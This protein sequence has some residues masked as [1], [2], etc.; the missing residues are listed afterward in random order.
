V[1]RVGLAACLGAEVVAG[2]LGFA[3]TV[4]LARRL[5]PS[6]FATV[7]VALATSAWLLV[8]VRGG[9]DQVVVREAARRP[10]LIPRLTGLLLGLRLAWAAAGFVLLASIAWIGHAGST[11]MLA[12][13]L[14]LLA[15]ALVADVG[16]RARNELPLLAAIQTTR[17][18]GM[19]CFVALAVSGPVDVVAAALA[20]GVAEAIVAIS[21]AVRAARVDGW[22]RPRWGWRAA[23]VLSGRAAVA[24]LTR[25]V[26]V[27]LYA[28]DAIALMLTAG[29]C[30]PYAAGRRVV[31]VS[32]AVGLVVPT[33]LAPGLTRAR[34]KGIEEA[35]AQIGRGVGLLLGLALPAALGLM[36]TSGR[37]LPFLFGDDY[38]AG[39]VL[40][41]LVAARLPILLAAAW[42][43]S[44]LVAI[45]RERAALASTLVAGLVALVAL[46][47]AAVGL[48]PLGI[49]A[50]ALGVEAVAGVGGWV[51]LRRSGVGV[52]RGVG[53]DR[54]IVG[55]AGLAA[56][57]A[58]TASAPL[59]IT[60]LAGAIG[61]AAGWGLAG[62]CGIR[63][64]RLGVETR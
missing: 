30:G 3:A 31:F 56:S 42:F 20:P 54:L 57:V 55:C 60:C 9:L 11:V 64:A 27:G 2:A 47:A 40:L 46:P 22:P 32:V 25:F 49:G 38:R 51:A 61:Y 4:H 48:G 50:A 19:L 15:S 21:C 59:P 26:R 10:R 29:A 28:A 6:G 1:D 43:G 7:E 62:T 8:L 52:F 58:L 23:R 17:A 36:L 45:G 41:A 37:I 13:G 39:G 44:A 5:G 24:G 63:M 16:P 34:A 18:L 53:W 12:S 14:V 35:T 33:L